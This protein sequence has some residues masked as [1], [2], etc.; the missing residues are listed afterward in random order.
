MSSGNKTLVFNSQER[1]VSTDHNRA[2]AFRDRMVAEL[3]RGVF[4]TYQGNDELDAG[5]NASEFAAI[6]A[7]MRGEIFSGLMVQPLIATTGIVITPG[8]AMMLA[9]DGGYD[10]SNY[11]FISDAGSPAG[12]LS[13]PANV[14]GLIRIDVI[15]CQVAQIVIETDNRDVLNLV[16]GALNATLVNKVVQGDLIYR[17]RS[18]TAGSGFPGVVSGWLPLAVASVPGTSSNNDTVTFWDVRPLVSDRQFGPFNMDDTVPVIGPRTILNMSSG[19]Q[20]GGVT[21]GQYA[22]CVGRTQLFYGGRRLGGRLRR[23]TPGVDSDT[24]DLCHP[25]NIEQGITF[26][27]LA[28]QGIYGYLLTPFNLPRWAR[29]TDASSGVRRPRSPRGIYVLTNKAPNVLSGDPSA[30]IALPASTGLL[31]TSYQGAAFFGTVVNGTAGGGIST[32]QIND[33]IQIESPVRQLISG[34]TPISSY[35]NFLMVPGVNYPTNARALWVDIRFAFSMGASSSTQYSANIYVNPSN[36]LAG[37][38]ANYTDCKLNPNAELMP[39]M[40]SPASGPTYLGGPGLIRV[41]IPYLYPSKTPKTW[42]I[43]VNLQN[44]LTVNTV[45]VGNGQCAVTQIEY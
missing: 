12:A 5:G 27:A 17:V 20:T 11:K 21:A 42:S 32:F 4:N 14:T 22:N 18:G 45:T 41:P 34:V 15:E 28:G 40:A 8:T 19:L 29:Y 6:E 44:I 36:Y 7:P 35:Y 10:D 31:G 26:G 2:Q 13:I 37:D 9:P 16:T 33:N 38:F 30:P 23:G 39:S 3:L 25:D 1:F 24:L 43:R